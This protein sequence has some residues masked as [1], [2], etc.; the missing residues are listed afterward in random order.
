MGRHEE[1]VTLCAPKSIRFT[2]VQMEILD[3]VRKYYREIYG[4]SI[5][6]SELV[7]LVIAKHMEIIDE[8]LYIRFISEDEPLISLIKRGMNA[9]DKVKLSELTLKLAKGEI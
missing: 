7:R 1:K 5:T 9:E 4:T 3:E 8:S 6:F 2:P